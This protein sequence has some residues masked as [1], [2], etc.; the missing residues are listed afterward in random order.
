[1][2]TPN[3]KFK[4]LSMAFETGIYN[5]I[6]HANLHILAKLYNCSYWQWLNRTQLM[7]EKSETIR[8]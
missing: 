2:K 4:K 1:M 8:K 3:T 6:K 7:K 5:V